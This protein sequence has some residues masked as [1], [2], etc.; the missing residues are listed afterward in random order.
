MR[1]LRN[2]KTGRTYIVNEDEYKSLKEN[3]HLKKFTVTTIE[4]IQKL[5]PIPGMIKPDVKITKI[6]AKK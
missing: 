4:P 1:E 6:K 2:K 3:G 5:I